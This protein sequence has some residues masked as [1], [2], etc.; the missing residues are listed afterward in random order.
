[1][2]VYDIEVV[3]LI[4]GLISLI[5]KTTLPKRYIP[6]ISIFIG[7]LVFILALTLTTKFFLIVLYIRSFN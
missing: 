5:K 3:P 7:I 6:I 1:M 2:E 4:V